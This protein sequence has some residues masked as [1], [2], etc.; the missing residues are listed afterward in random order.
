MNLNRGLPPVERLETPA[1]A[2]SDVLGVE[3]TADAPAGGPAV[4]RVG[5]PGLRAAPRHARGGD[6]A[7]RSTWT[8][9]TI[10]AGLQ[11]ES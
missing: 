5:D 8:R 4:V 6:L 2:L 3:M 11:V 10:L 9:A 7:G 1:E